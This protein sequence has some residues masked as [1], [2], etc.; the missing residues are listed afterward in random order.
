MTVAVLL[1]GGSGSRFGGEQPKQF[2]V[3]AGKSILAHTI[4]V[5]ESHP[6][7]DEIAIVTRADSMEETQR[8]VA[9]GGYQKVKRFLTG[10]RERYHSSLAAINAYTDDETRLL[11]HDAVRPLVSHRIIS[12]CIHALD[13]YEAVDV[14]IPATD[15]IIRVDEHDCIV[16]TP[17]RAMLR[18]V[19]TPQG[20]LRGTISRA[21]EIGLRDPAFVTTD[22]CGVVHHYLPDTPIYVVRGEVTNI[23]ITYPE[24]LMLLKASPTAPSIPSDARPCAA[25]KKSE[26][27]NN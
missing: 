9:E 24:D 14:A 10:G 11:I 15:T 12:D 6:L 5:F 20:F 8:I 21:Y 7:I 18:N 4:D 3:V 13:H 27:E 22:D 2:L 16:E 17:P 1:A 25:S 19:Q 23:K 26:G